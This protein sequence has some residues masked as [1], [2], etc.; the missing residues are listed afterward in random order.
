[1]PHRSRFTDLA[2]LAGFLALCL[3]VGAIGGWASADGV[4]SWYGTLNKPSFNPPNWVFG[5]VWTVLYIL[6][7]IAAW[8][9]WRSAA[10]TVVRKPLLLF[11]V[12]LALNLAWSIVFFKLQGIAAS[13]AVIVLLELMLLTTIVAFSRIDRWASL[14]LMPYLLWVAFAT[15]LDVA[16]WRLN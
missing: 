15:T 7:A 1:M 16:I 3:G 2:V 11:G 10:W 4:R 14:L 5:P 6:M 9:V 13:V 12:Q 8:R